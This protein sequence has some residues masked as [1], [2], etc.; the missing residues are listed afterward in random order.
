VL[1]I[2]RGSGPLRDHLG[3]RVGSY[4]GVDLSREALAEAHARP[5]DRFIH[6]DFSRY[7]PDRPY[8]VIAS[9]NRSTTRGTRSRRPR[10][11]GRSNVD[12]LGRAEDRV[13]NN[14]DATGPLFTTIAICVHVGL[15]I[16]STVPQFAAP[17][18]YSRLS[19][20]VSYATAA[21]ARLDPL[22]APRR[23]AADRTDGLIAEASRAE[24]RK[25]E[26]ERHRAMRGSSSSVP[27][28]IARRIQKI[29]CATSAAVPL[30]IRCAR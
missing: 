29:R 19:W 20:M 9:T 2:G 22:S 30:E 5:G 7:L 12:R 11:T 18:S 23:T 4:A 24:H 8:D 3:D 15:P 21:D 1:D 6:A 26:R 10:S 27:T 28:P 14:P 16:A 25:R 17:M 13:P